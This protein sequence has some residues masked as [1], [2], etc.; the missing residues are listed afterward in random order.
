[1][2]LICVQ[3]LGPEKMTG[4]GEKNLVVVHKIT[5]QQNLAVTVVRVCRAYVARSC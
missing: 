3:T 2:R 1:M 5:S 4:S